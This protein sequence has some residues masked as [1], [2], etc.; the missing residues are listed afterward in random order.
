MKDTTISK[1]ID[2]PLTFDPTKTF[3]ILQLR[4]AYNNGTYTENLLGTAGIV[5]L[6]TITIS[7]GCRSVNTA[8]TYVYQVVEFQTDAT[9]QTAAVNMPYNVT[10]VNA[11]LA[12]A[13]GAFNKAI[14]FTQYRGNNSTLDGDEGHIMIRGNIDETDVNKQRL[15]FRKEGTS[16]STTD[17]VTIRYYLVEFSDLGSSVQKITRQLRQPCRHPPSRRSPKRRP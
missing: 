7:R 3:V 10:S 9:I 1:N 5:D 17:T 14:L 2:L 8:Q 16:T 11:N 13:I 15:V 4:A 6:D 12:A